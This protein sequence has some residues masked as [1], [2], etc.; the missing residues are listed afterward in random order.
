MRVRGV[1]CRFIL[2]SNND[3]VLRSN[4]VGHSTVCR[5][6]PCSRE[7]C[8]GKPLGAWILHVRRCV[9]MQKPKIVGEKGR[10]CERFGQNYYHK[11]VPTPQSHTHSS[12]SSGL[13]AHLQAIPPIQGLTLANP[14]KNL[15]SGFRLLSFQLCF[16]VW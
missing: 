13:I 8:H 10:P 4:Q 9:C 14:P 11:T 7:P 6:K 3:P 16:F 1:P 2:N 15:D 5:L 12:S